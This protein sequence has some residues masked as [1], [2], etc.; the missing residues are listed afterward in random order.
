M[1]KIIKAVRSL[2]R[3]ITGIANHINNLY[4]R[5]DRLEGELFVEDFLVV[6][7]KATGPVHLRKHEAVR[8]EHKGEVLHT[9]KKNYE[10]N[11]EYVKKLNHAS[12]SKATRR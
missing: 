1:I 9:S 4:R 6:N 11:Q 10:A 5:V 7:N 8:F 2:P 12:K 3:T